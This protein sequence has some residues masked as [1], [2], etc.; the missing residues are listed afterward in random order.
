MGKVTGG[1]VEWKGKFGLI[2]PAEEVDHPAAGKHK[3][4]LYIHTQDLL[5]E[6]ELTVGTKCRFYIFS[7]ASG[8]GAEELTV[9]KNG[10]KDMDDDDGWWDE[11]GDW[12]DGDW[13]DWEDGEWEDA[14]MKD[15]GDNNSGG[16]S[17]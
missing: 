9:L 3:G 5:Y 6:N 14:E 12:E 13:E 7:D 1:V 15:G 10:D 2:K 8:L 17:D 4:K 11:S 16:A